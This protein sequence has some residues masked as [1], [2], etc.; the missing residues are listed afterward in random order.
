MDHC[1]R[2]ADGA[3]GAKYSLSGN[4]TAARRRAGGSASR[5]AATVFPCAWYCGEYPHDV[6]LKGHVGMIADNAF[7]GYVRH[8]GCRIVARRSLRSFM[9]SFPDFWCSS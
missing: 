6:S 7:T 9:G 1:A 8:D 4:S 2:L 3:R 5:S